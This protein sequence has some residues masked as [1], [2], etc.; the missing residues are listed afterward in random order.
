MPYVT[1]G[2]TLISMK[3]ILI[4]EVNWVGDILFT[5]PAIRAI[6]ESNPKSF[7]ACLA[8][9]RCIEILE[10]N[11]GIDEIIV[12]DEKGSH[13]GPFSKVSLI[14]ELRKRHFDTVI[15]FHRSMTRML[16]AALAG[17]P[18]RIG[19][20]TR[21]RS[22]LLTDPVAVP[23]ERLHRV[24]YFLN[25][26]RAAGIETTNKNYQFFISE[27]S[28]IKADQILIENGIDKDEDFFLINP[29]GN[30][31]PKRW[32]REKYAQLC[33][34]LK[35]RYGKKIVIT[36]AEKDISLAGDIMRMSGNCAVSI[37]GKTTLKELAAVMRR[38]SLVVSND[39]GPMHIAVSQKVP[40]IAIFGPTDPAITGPYG[41][42]RYIILHKWKDCEIPCYDLS[43]RDFRC[44]EAVSVEDVMD[45]VER[46]KAKG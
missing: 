44:M 33:R 22:W 46:L 38:A 30:W 26:T 1:F 32:P 40:T 16:I 41:D 24:E 4:I 2:N 35:D 23:E 20:Y 13:R 31:P 34:R 9:P 7:I 10:G 39:S 29:G 36:G 45:A 43:C 3:R 8:L 37:C 21:K 25:I 5:T 11:P 19:Y 12:L 18:R 27:A 14:F 42:G 17:I 28:S 6:R 15:S